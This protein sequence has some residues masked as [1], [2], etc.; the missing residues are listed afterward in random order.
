MRVTLKNIIKKPRVLLAA[1]KKH[2]QDKLDKTSTAEQ[3]K[4]TIEK[5]P[6]TQADQPKTLGLSPAQLSEKIQIIAPSKVAETAQSDSL[7]SNSSVNSKQQTTNH[8]SVEQNV[9]QAVDA[10][11]KA[12]NATAQAL[13]K[14]SF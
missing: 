5:Q 2:K 13:A 7:V 8:I 14:V 4:T 11:M 3:L 6:I 10:P 12:A 9:T 1:Y